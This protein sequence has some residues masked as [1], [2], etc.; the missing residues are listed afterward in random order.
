MRLI[1]TE[2]NFLLRSFER[3]F[4]YPLLGRAGLWGRC[5]AAIRLSHR[6][7]PS[8]RAVRVRSMDWT[9]EDDMD[10]GL[11]FCATLTGPRGGHTRLYQQERKRPTPVRRRLS[12]TQAFL[13]RVIPGVC[14]QVTGIKVRSS[15]GLSAHLAFYWW[16][17]HC[18]ARML[19]LSLLHFEHKARPNCTPQ[20]VLN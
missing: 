9:L 15:E 17:A 6:P 5:W 14:V 3:V 16:S 8:G 20:R 12:R 2:R 13:G 7:E 4:F 11:F 18:A 10:N 19:L 1:A